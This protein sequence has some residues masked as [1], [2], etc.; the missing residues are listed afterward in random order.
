MKKFKN[1]YS[2]LTSTSRIKATKSLQLRTFES[3]WGFFRSKNLSLDTT[4]GAVCHFHFAFHDRSDI[5]NEIPLTRFWTICSKWNS[6]PKQIWLPQSNRKEAPHF[7]PFRYYDFLFGYY[8]T[9]QYYYTPLNSFE[10]L[11]LEAG[12]VIFLGLTNTADKMGQIL[13]SQGMAGPLGG[14]RWANEAP[15]SPF[16][17]PYLPCPAIAP[18]ITGTI[19]LP[20][21]FV[22]YHLR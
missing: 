1:L 14:R 7:Q 11:L 18:Y 8:I 17:A 19:L 10:K 5:G 6:N 22:A 4:K 2:H 16:L 21:A 12:C 9:L 13:P 15:F 3:K 20:I